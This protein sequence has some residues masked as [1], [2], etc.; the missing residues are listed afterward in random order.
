MLTL[1]DHIMQL[2]GVATR[3]QLL[4]RGFTGYQMTAA[5]RTGLIIRVRQGYYCTAETDVA[6]RVAVFIGGSVGCVT[7]AASYGLWAGNDTRVH[8]TVPDDATRLRPKKPA[9]RAADEVPPG[10]V[11]HWSPEPRPAVGGRET[12][13]VSPAECVRQVMRCADAETAIASWATALRSG[14]LSVDELAAVA[15][16][17]PAAARHRASQVRAGADSGLEAIAMHRVRLLGLDVRQQVEIGG[18]GRVDALIEGR[19]VLEID[20]YAYHSAP[21]RFEN[22]RRRDALLTAAGYVVI[23]LSYQQ[24]MNDWAFCRAC[25]LGALA[26]H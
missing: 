16:Q 4:H 23:R 17:L 24:V 10:I 7:A 19:V 26:T 5:V 12:W 9:F 8:V 18:V 14:L 2:G 13:R 25:I 6:K 22:D 3:R 1:A 20:G 15:V 21:D 11:L